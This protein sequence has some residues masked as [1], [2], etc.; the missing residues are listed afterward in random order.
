MLESDEVATDAGEVV[1][2]DGRVD[3]WAWGSFSLGINCSKAAM[4]KAIAAAQE[5]EN[6]S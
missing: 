1:I 2:T 4:A 3:L 5:L 6:Q